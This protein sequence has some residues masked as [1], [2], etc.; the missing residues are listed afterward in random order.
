M[1]AHDCG[2]VRAVGR[3][4][5]VGARLLIVG[6]LAT[7]C[8]QTARTVT[9]YDPSANFSRFHTYSWRQ[10]TP[11][12]RGLM[13]ERI[14]QSVNRELKRKGLIQ[15]EQG[16]DLE[17]RYFITVDERLDISWDDLD[18]PYWSFWDRRLH[19]QTIAR[20]VPEGTIVV[21]L[22]DARENQVVWRGV[23]VDELN[24]RNGDLETQ[25]SFVAAEMFE[26]YPPRPR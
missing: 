26:D 8:A 12:D 10:S 11:T 3:R 7:A 2:R 20:E 14:I 24:E 17:V 18:S 6:F 13:D 1:K 19:G 21:D 9:N 15:V 25:I 23:S 5:S 16:G 22:I 4:A